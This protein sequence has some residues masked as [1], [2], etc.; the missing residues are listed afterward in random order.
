MLLTWLV[1]EAQMPPNFFGQAVMTH[2]SGGAFGNSANRTPIVDGPV[3]KIIDVHNPPYTN[4]NWSASMYSHSQWMANRMGQVFGLA[5]DTIGNIYASA[6]SNYNFDLNDPL[7]YGSAGPGGVYKIDAFTGNVTDLV[8]SVPY[9][10]TNVLGTS[11]LPNGDAITGPGLGNICYDVIHH[12]LFLTNFEDGKIYRINPSSGIVEDIYD[13]VVPA[14]YGGTKNPAMTLD[15]GTKGFTN[16]GDRTWGIAYN[17]KENRLYYGVWVELRVSNQSANVY[18]VVR[19]VGFDNMGFMD[20]NKDKLEVLVPNDHL[21]DHDT[22]GTSAAIS[23]IAFAIKAYPKKDAMS[24]A[25]ISMR[26]DYEKYVG[27]SYQYF[28]NTSMGWER[29]NQYANRLYDRLHVGLFPGT[30]SEGG[31]DYGYTNYTNGVNTGLNKR[32][33]LTGITLVNFSN[34]YVDGLQSIPDTGNLI[35]NA[36]QVGHFIDWDNTP[37]IDHFRQGDVELY[38]DC[39]EP[40]YQL[41]NLLPNDGFENGILPDD[42]GQFESNVNQWVA[43]T[44]TPDV[45]DENFTTCGLLPCNLNTNNCI[46]IPCNY[47]GEEANN[48]I[49]SGKR[50]AGLWFAVGNNLKNQ[51]SGTGVSA[52]VLELVGDATEIAVEGVEAQMQ[53]LDTSKSYTVSFYVS[54]AEKG[55]VADLLVDPEAHF[56]VKMSKSLKK[57]PDLIN[58]N[59]VGVKRY[60]PVEA[61]IIYEG[62]TSNINGWQKIEF[63]FTPKKEYEYLI[64]ESA[65]GDELRVRLKDLVAS[66]GAD[67]GIE[68]YMYIDDIAIQETCNNTFPVYVGPDTYLCSPVPCNTYPVYTLSHPS[69]GGAAPY[70]FSWSPSDGLSNPNVERPMAC[71]TETTTYTVTVTDANG[72]TG[73]D[74]VTVF[75]SDVAAQ[76]GP[77]IEG[78]KNDV[79]RIYGNVAGGFGPYTYS[80]SPAGVGGCPT[81]QW[82]DIKFLGTETYTLTVTDANG[83]SGSDS[84][85]AKEVPSVNEHVNNGGYET[86]GQPTGSGEFE[87]KVTNWFAAAGEP[88]LFDS[89]FNC[90]AVGNFDPDCVDIPTNYAGYEHHNGSGRRYAGLWAAVGQAVDRK[91]GTTVDV[92]FMVEGIET[93]LN[94]PIDPNKY[95]EMS[96]DVSRG[97]RG[98]TGGS[99]ATA[100]ESEFTVK[101]SDTPEISTNYKPISANLAYKGKTDKTNGWETISFKFKATR[102]YEYLIIQSSIAN[103]SAANITLQ[104]LANYVATF[105]IPPSVPPVNIGLESYLYIDNVSIK[106]LCDVP[107]SFV[108]IAH[109]ATKSASAATIDEKEIDVTIFPN[110]ARDNF[111]ITGLKASN[112]VKVYNLIGEK[113]MEFEQTID[114]NDV[115]MIEAKKWPTGVYIIDILDGTQS[116]RREKISIIR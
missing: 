45:Y 53:K 15:D 103:L 66:M 33:W 14:N 48:A 80:W 23:D 106:E 107:S 16:L 7:A 61:D 68:T 2:I 95:Y 101:F 65:F 96:F 35:N 28:G 34:L 4:A 109:N 64:I 50:Y 6:T 44:G 94:T 110:P 69:Y 59:G 86:G 77:D 26:Q 102:Q 89:Q 9:S 37:N 76:A 42:R 111:T 71:P 17:P 27:T 60:D 12:K 82:I 108:T 104:D 31:V 22:V 100:K 24:I 43:A 58:V 32:I 88:D 79:K 91:I 11:T 74:Q 52:A 75:V 98:K 70:S 18:N 51:L 29:P 41:V 40:C 5:V 112:S 36:Q 84:F 113:I 46:G 87:N 90:F 49:T 114:S 56:V 3:I 62:K 54:K 73:T 10:T 63:T 81:C 38:R 8:T 57:N 47:F 55:E 19:S 25:G 105:T 67:K 39:C 93:R 85:I 30:K 20:G 1:T 115:L 92:Y 116:V 21:A 97:E 13:P 72:N 83:C 99:P 78:C